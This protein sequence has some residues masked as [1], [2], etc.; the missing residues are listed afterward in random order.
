MY[1]VVNLGGGTMKKK[2]FSR[3][4]AVVLCIILAFSSLSVAYAN[5]V[6]ASLLGN[7]VS[8]SRW[9]SQI[10][11]D[12]LLSDMSLPGTHDSGTKWINTPIAG[13]WTTTQDLT[14]PD[15]LASGVRYLDIRLAYDS[16]KTGGAK[17]MHSTI[18]CL[19]EYNATMT[20]TDVC[21]YLMNFLSGNPTETVVVSIKEDAGDAAQALADAVYNTI[22]SS[23][24]SKYWYTGYSTPTLRNVRGK[25]VLATRIRQYPG[26]I[27]LN[28]GDQGSDG[29]AVDNGLYKV[30]D[31][32]NMGA[33]NKWNNAVKP[34]FDETKPNGKWYINFL[35][36]T[37]GGISGVSAN[38]GT[39]NS[40]FSRYEMVNN[41]CYGI[42]A[43][44][45]VSENL[46]KKVYKCNDLVTK[47]QP[48]AASGQYYYR[49]NI[50]TT[51]NV[52]DGWT[53]V[54]LRL[55]YK[56]KNGTGNESSIL[57]FDN[58]D[59]YNG[60][61]F[62]C[63]IG[64]WDFSGV[65]NG[66]PTKAEF[67]Y[68]WGY[69]AKTLKQDLNLYVSGSPSGTMYKCASN[70]FVNSSY[71]GKPCVGTEYYFTP[72]SLFP[73][74]VSVAFNDSNGIV[75]VPGINSSETYQSP[76]L[77][78]VYDQY[79][80]KWYENVTRYS[81]NTTYTGVSLL[82]GVLHISKAANNNP[83]LAQFSILAEFSNSSTYRFATKTLSLNTNKIQ[84]FFLNSDANV[85]QEGYEY[86]GVVPNYLGP[87]PVKEPTPTIHYIFNGWDNSNA[88]SLSNTV[89]KATYVPGEHVYDMGVC[90]CGKSLDMSAYASIM[91]VAKA[92]LN[93]TNVYNEKSLN[94]L[95]Q[96]IDKANEK[97]TSLK[98]QTEVDQ[99][100]TTIQYA[101]NDL[102]L[103]PYKVTF[104]YTYVDSDEY[105]VVTPELNYSEQGVNTFEV[106]N[107]LEGS[108]YKWS[109][110]TSDGD[111]A[112]SVNSKQFEYNITEDTLVTCY[113]TEKESQS[114]DCK[115]TFIGKGI[116][117]V[118]YIKP[119]K[120]N[121]SIVNGEI[122]L[123]S[124][125]VCTSVVPFYNL[126]T[127]TIN[128]TEYK[129][130]QSVTLSEDTTIYLNYE[131]K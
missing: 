36:T 20:F 32:Y 92:K 40:Y 84:Y 77:A 56:D 10:K 42:V 103:M 53:S 124:Q 9:M 54:S 86:Y 2:I 61:Q 107:G 45:Y 113:L 74:P 131:A 70:S 52:A 130:R 75:N 89:Y 120:H 101:I 126:K 59:Q 73:K 25:A 82:G 127:L 112:F 99:L 78:S 3:L 23:T 48:N 16:A 98:G 28:W 66:F 22:N 58:T 76:Q 43:F 97:A 96:A 117:Y 123:S 24:Y 93:Q 64:N 18:E 65:V 63:N 21:R 4:L 14:I 118:T 60:Y 46:A 111:K 68:D 67:K 122:R 44:D 13:A 83:H 110:N 87:T 35:S 50:N 104:A 88:I 31:R 100:V 81:L 115:V 105:V 71:I 129:T 55:Y 69:G 38:A 106:P 79:G 11:D 15:Q 72:S 12:T 27:S 6:T 114:T 62:V 26:G 41:K 1:N 51:Q 95:Q 17:V 102:E 119:G 49:I 33:D 80:I 90:I 47:T 125:V 116:K 94:A 57:I 7:T 37:G 8:S 108:V 128:G 29:G 5:Y 34:M 85:L 39:M 91:I 121:L 109:V 30:Q 19:N